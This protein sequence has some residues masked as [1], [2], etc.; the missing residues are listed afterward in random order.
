MSE[1]ML[2]LEICG[3][4]MVS[5][6]QQ[7]RIMAEWRWTGDFQA[8]TSYTP[9]THPPFISRASYSFRPTLI[10]PPSCPSTPS[11]PS[12]LIARRRPTHRLK[13]HRTPAWPTTRRCLAQAHCPKIR[14][15]RLFCWYL[16]SS[17]PFSQ[18]Q[19]ATS[20]RAHVGQRS[21]PIADRSRPI[22]VRTHLL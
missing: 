4:T 1:V 10:V 12:K 21:R 8:G 7:R 3:F 2:P 6:R 14:S 13:P 15:P 20:Q 18:R 22:A 17:L 19:T 9:R 11:S 16:H 5:E